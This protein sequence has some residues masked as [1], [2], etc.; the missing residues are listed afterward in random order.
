MECWKCH[1]EGGRADGESAPTLEDDWGFLIR[2]RNL[3]KEWHFKR[4]SSVVDI[5]T[6]LATGM[7]GSPMPSFLLDL[8]DDDRWAIS[9]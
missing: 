8:D 5:Y 6:R 7:D 9:A 2:P 4:G 3:T 1:G